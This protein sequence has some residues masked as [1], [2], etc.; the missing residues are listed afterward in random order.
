MCYNHII[1]KTGLVWIMEGNQ[2]GVSGQSRNG[3]FD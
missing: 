2:H 1:P 3:A